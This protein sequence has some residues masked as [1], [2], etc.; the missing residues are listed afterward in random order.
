MTVRDLIRREGALSLERTAHII[1][2]AAAALHAAHKQGIIHRDIKPDNIMVRRND[3]GE[4]EVKVLDFGI[5][6]MLDVATDGER[7]TLTG[8]VVGTPQYLSPEQCKGSPLDARSDVYALGIVTYEMLSAAVPFDGPTP[9]TVALKHI[10]E[11]AQPLGEVVAGLAPEIDVVVQRAIAK[12]PAHRYQTTSDFARDL[13]ATARMTASRAASGHGDVGT[14]MVGVPRPPQHGTMRSLPPDT[15]QASPRPTEPWVEGWTQGARPVGQPPTAAHP[16]GPTTAQPAAPPTRVFAGATGHA[17][18]ASAAPAPPPTAAIAPP[19]A[20]SRA[21]LVALLAVAGV[22]LFGVLAILAYVVATRSSQ[23]VAAVPAAEPGVA[24]TP[25]PTPAPTPASAPAPV[26][27]PVLDC[28]L[29]LSAT[30]D[31]ERR[32]GDLGGVVAVA[33]GEQRIRF[34]FTP[35]RKGYLYLVATLED[36]TWAQVTA[37]PTKQK[38][39]TNAIDVGRDVTVPGATDTYIPYVGPVTFTVVYSPTQLAAPAFFSGPSGRQLTADE[40]ADWERFRT[41][42]TVGRLEGGSE[43]DALTT[44]SGPDPSGEPKALAFTITLE[45]R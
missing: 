9:F 17:A 33:P 40:V 13:T 12:D 19:P 21:A 34:H 36:G 41:S 42:A 44:L 24:P 27:V 39:Q 28:W 29:G 37:N 38:L 35:R 3:E 11:L 32:V 25:T 22:L 43:R 20:S 16:Q 7:L 31:R 18:V 30:G 10:S 45:R 2:R 26:A 6:K 14:I 15:P 23:P 1:E 4:E 8:T 5:A